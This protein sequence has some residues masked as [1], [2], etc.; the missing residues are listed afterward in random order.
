[1]SGGGGGLSNLLSGID[2]NTLNTV[3]AQL[4][5]SGD[6]LNNLRNKV[7]S[8]SLGPDELQNLSA[9][10]GSLNMSSSQI[11]A[12]TNTLGL[13][14][15][16]VQTIQQTLASAKGTSQPGMSGGPPPAGPR[17][18]WHATRRDAT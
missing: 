15:S 16:Q 8:G 11:G 4:G 3:A 17:A 2:Q 7:S 18:A 9:R 12:I 13:N 14:A 6:Q 5:V 1:M 10:F